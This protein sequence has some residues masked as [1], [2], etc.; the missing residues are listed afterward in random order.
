MLKNNST[1]SSANRI[2]S[3][4]KTQLFL[5]STLVSKYIIACKDNKI[6]STLVKISF[7]MKREPYDYRMRSLF[8]EIG[9]VKYNGDDAWKRK[10]YYEKLLLIKLVIKNIG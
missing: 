4:R 10:V 9:S 1:K 7:D 3:K 6:E 8:M 5:L 2:H